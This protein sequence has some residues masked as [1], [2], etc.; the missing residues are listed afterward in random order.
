MD[1]H[2]EDLSKAYWETLSLKMALDSNIFKNVS[3][4][5]QVVSADGV[6]AC[7][8][9][10]FRGNK[11]FKCILLKVC[12]ELGLVQKKD[13]EAYELSAL[14]QRFMASCRIRY[15]LQDRYLKVWL[16][17]LQIRQE[18]SNQDVFKELSNDKSALRLSHEVLA[19]Y[20]KQD[21]SGIVDYLPIKEGDTI[22][23]LGGGTGSL[24]EEISKTITSKR[25]RLVCLDRPE[26]IKLALDRT[27]VSNI[28]F[29]AGDLFHGPLP[30]ANTYLLS[31]V[32]H[33]WD[34]EKSILILDHIYKNSIDSVKLCIIDRYAS[35]ENAHAK[36]SL[37]MYL[38]QNSYERSKG[39][40]NYL[41]ARSKWNLSGET[42]YNS[43]II[44][45][46]KKYI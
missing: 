39:Q 42:E 37:H 33:D 35:D 17:N 19:S 4:D 5:I 11:R 12:E 18:I 27:D 41:F 3:H 20:A 31:R 7:P 6:T 28:L 15:W 36:L 23:D 43:H 45:T 13:K 9:E 1:N 25:L 38:I 10:K 29:T 24:L 2:L 44:F 16:P 14:G 40:W 8:P 30:M 21:W 22:C 32:I 34:D 46:L 26:V